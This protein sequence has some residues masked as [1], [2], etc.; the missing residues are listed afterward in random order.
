MAQ[1]RQLPSKAFII[2]ARWTA[3]KPVKGWRHYRISAVTPAS[4][5]GSKENVKGTMVEMMAVCDREVRFWISRKELIADLNWVT[6][7]LHIP[8]S[9]ESEGFQPS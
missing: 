8:D 2:N 7:W 6:G 1:K 3:L 5:G 4:R 9:G